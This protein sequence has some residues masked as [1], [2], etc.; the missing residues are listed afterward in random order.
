M[1]FAE[2]QDN[3]RG[4]TSK[5]KLQRAGGFYRHKLEISKDRSKDF[6]CEPA[7]AFSE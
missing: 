4:R 6:L 7:K 5:S 3:L 1:A 2:L